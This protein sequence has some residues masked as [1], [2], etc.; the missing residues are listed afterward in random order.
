MVSALRIERRDFLKQGIA[1]AGGLAVASALPLVA[2]PPVPSTAPHISFPVS[3]RERISIAS[4]PFREFIAGRREQGA[5]GGK[6]SLK[7]FGAHVA[8][9]FGV[10]HI[11]PWSA[12]FSS[13]DSDY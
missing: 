6:L 2:A 7:D 13:L 9:K 3:P 4:Y 11:E 5:A 10:S 8:A 12:H 1:A